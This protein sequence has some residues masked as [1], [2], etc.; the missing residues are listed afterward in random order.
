[1]TYMTRKATYLT[2]IFSCLTLFIGMACTGVPAEKAT[3]EP[4]NKTAVDT[5]A[6]T[7]GMQHATFAFGCFWHSEEMMLELKGVVDAVP[8]YA[9]GTEKNP[10][11]KLVSSKST[12]YAESVDISYDPK[13]ITYKQLLMVFFAEHDPTTPNYSEPDEGPEYRSV[14]FYRNE[15]QKSEI[16]S[17]ISKLTT[18]HKYENPIITEVA[19]FTGFTK[20][21]DYHIHYYRHHKNDGGYITSVTGAEIKKFREDFKEWLKE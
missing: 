17:Y 3:P 14:A 1:M 13:V 18:Q 8:G 12:K 15:S 10:T 5:P 4:D 19:P 21:E 6:D 20:A 2:I 7:T 16:E 9:G 11:Y